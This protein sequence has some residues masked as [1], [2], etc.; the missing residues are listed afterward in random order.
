MTDATLRRLP[1]DDRA[2]TTCE[3]CRR[4]LVWAMTVAGPNGRGGKLMP[5][6]P[7]EDLAGNVAVTAP[8]RGRLLARVLTKGET[9][10]RPHEY[11]AMTHFASC[12]TGTKPELPMDVLQQV[13]HK[14]RSRGGRHR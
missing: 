5:L 11:A 4:E 10:D 14:P 1:V 13:R 2:R 7:L 8:H 6:D 12:P 9:F 3:G